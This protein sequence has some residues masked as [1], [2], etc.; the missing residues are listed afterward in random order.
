MDYQE[1]P[2]DELTELLLTE[3]DRLPRAAVDEFIRRGDK[4]I[5]FLEEIV[6]D[7]FHWTRDVP[8]WWAVVHAAFILGAIGTK[9]T[10]IPLLRALR[11]ADAFDCDWVTEALPAIFGRIGSAAILPLKTMAVDRTNGCYTRSI[12]MEGLGLIAWRNPGTKE[13]ISAFIYSIFSDK[14]NDL[15]VRQSAGSTLLDLGCPQYREPLLAFGRQEKELKRQNKFYLAHFFDDDVEKAFKAG[16]KNMKDFD[17][18]WLSFYDEDEIRKRQKR[19]EE[20]KESE[21]EEEDPGRLITSGERPYVRQT[22]TGRND[23]CPCGSGK[24]YKKCCLGK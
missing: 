23:P 3:E 24:K 18:D 17:R 1:F 19:W 8:K 16:G 11:W 13:E 2:E 22:F 10:I 9:T 4:M 7:Q 14:N 21:P 20:E 15:D 12:A 6:S 5:P